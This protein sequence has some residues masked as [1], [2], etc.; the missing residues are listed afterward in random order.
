MIKTSKQNDIEKIML[1]LGITLDI[2]KKSL[3]QREN[4]L[5]LS[6]EQIEILNRHHINYNNY[7][8]LS[9]LIFKI[10]EYIEEVGNY[11]EIT[12]IDELSKQ[13]SEQ[14]YYQNTNK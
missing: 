5:L 1:E 11:M 14:N 9:S 12:D 10:E 8:N 3:K 2:E 4:G 6:D 7:N 13:L